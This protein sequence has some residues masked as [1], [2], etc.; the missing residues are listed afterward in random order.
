MSVGG[1]L[2]ISLKKS[3]MGVLRPRNVLLERVTDLWTRQRGCLAVEIS[4]RGRTNPD[5]R[6]HVGWTGSTLPGRCVETH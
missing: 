5:V 1:L 4:A 6:P 2:E 3:V